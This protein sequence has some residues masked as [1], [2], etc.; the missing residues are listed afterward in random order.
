MGK[1]DS[2]LKSGPNKGKSV[3]TG[4][5]YEFRPKQKTSKGAIVTISPKE[6]DIE[7]IIDGVFKFSVQ[8][9]HEERCSKKYICRTLII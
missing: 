2:I 9:H 3:L 8:S 4:I 6:K 5:G 7:V 1:P